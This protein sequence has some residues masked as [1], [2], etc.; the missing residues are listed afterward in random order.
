MTMTMVMGIATGT[1][2]ATTNQARLLDEDF[3]AQSFL[4]TLDQL[5]PSAW[6]EE[7]NRISRAV[8]DEE[9]T[10]A[11]GF[12]DEPTA[13]P[14]FKRISRRSGAQDVFLAT[15]QRFKQIQ[16]PSLSPRD[17]PTYG[18]ESMLARPSTAALSSFLQR[19]W[20]GPS[21]PVPD[22]L[23]VPLPP[24]TPPP[25]LQQTASP[26]SFL[27][28]HSSLSVDAT[29]RVQPQGL[30]LPSQFLYALPNLFNHRTD[31]T[32]PIA[33]ATGYRF[34]NQRTEAFSTTPRSPFSIMDL[35]AAR[36]KAFSQF[37]LNQSN[38]PIHDK[39]FPV[40]RVSVQNNA[41]ERFAQIPLPVH[42]SSRAEPPPLPP[43]FPVE[44]PKIPPVQPLKHVE[45]GPTPLSQ[46]LLSESQLSVLIKQALKD[47]LAGQHALAGQQ[48]H[49]S[50]VVSNVSDS[51]QSQPAAASDNQSSS[52]L[53]RVAVDPLRSSQMN[54]R[55]KTVFS[56][57][58]GW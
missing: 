9:L 48:T 31:S 4:R 53:T 52:T 36:R 30:S 19:P 20:E 51:V 54:P 26:S 27:E 55:T 5:H 32:P 22:L 58:D 45:G 34:S 50:T 11:R 24:H 44:S 21:T 29:S 49:R 37:T 16:L 56:D 1:T 47:A 46:P 57:S 43:L 25:H 35:M 40:Q 12:L 28:L 18:H 41:E 6:R 23:F 39:P 3:T 42:M 8:V 38:Q 7:L 14:D 15:E 10:K 33:D 17:A 2:M 13:L